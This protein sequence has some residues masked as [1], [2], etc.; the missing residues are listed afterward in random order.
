MPRSQ[1]HHSRAP[2]GNLTLI[3]DTQFGFAIYSSLKPVDIKRLFSMA[4][5]TIRPFNR[6]LLLE[7]LGYEAIDSDHMEISNS[8]FRA[9]NCV[10]LQFPF[11]IARMKK[12]MQRHFAREAEIM[13][14]LDSTLCACHQREH[15]ALLRFCDNT[16]KVS[17]YNWT[18]AQRF[19]RRDFP[20][21]I[22]E[23]IVCMDQLLVICVNTGGEIG[24]CGPT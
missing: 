19:L 13:T 12:L 17:Q 23:H 24:S 3:K 15:D 16:A 1:I 22:R 10:P 2:Y 20:G 11:L 7:Q 5:S 4:T 9:V 8:W 14:R 18:Q 21:H 6:K